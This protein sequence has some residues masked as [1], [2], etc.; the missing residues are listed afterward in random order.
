MKN[1]LNKIPKSK[2]LLTLWIVVISLLA[3]IPI[4]KFIY[5]HSQEHRILQTQIDM[6]EWI[7][8]DKFLE[9]VIDSSIVMA[10]NAKTPLSCETV[11]NVAIQMIGNEK[12]NKINAVK[13]VENLDKSLTEECQ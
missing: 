6:L 10:G 12:S 5:N 4:G 8:G 3:A 9:D 13:I 7:K 1:I 11:V 2:I